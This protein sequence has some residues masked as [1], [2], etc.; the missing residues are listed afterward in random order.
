MVVGVDEMEL[1]D[2]VNGLEE[3]GGMDGADRVERGGMK[4]KQ[5]M[6]IVGN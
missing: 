5:A 1:A 6:R 4:L 3:V 2:R